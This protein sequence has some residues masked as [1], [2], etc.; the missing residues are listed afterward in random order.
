MSFIIL[1]IEI[2]LDKILIL[3]SINDLLEFSKTCRS[4]NEYVFIYLKCNN[5]KYKIQEKQD[6]YKFKTCRECK[7]LICRNCQTFC[8]NYEYCDNIFC[9]DCLVT[10]ICEECEE[11]LQNT[12]SDEDY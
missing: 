11:Y 3:L 12:A 10:E 9:E 6:I 2:I 7:K 4:A 5:C 8:N 1:P